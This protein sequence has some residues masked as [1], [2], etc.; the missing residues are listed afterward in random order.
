M[1]KKY[2]KRINS[3]KRSDSGATFTIEFMFIFVVIFVLFMAMVD[4]GL[5]FNNRSLITNMTQDAARTVAIHGGDSTKITVS[6][7]NNVSP[8]VQLRNALNS[9]YSGNR[10]ITISS[11]TCS[12]RGEV[13][14]S[15]RDKTVSCSV[16]WTYSG[17]VGGSPFRM[18]PNTTTTTMYSVSEVWF[19]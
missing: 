18:S 15:S 17:L 1:F 2:T 6:K 4:L 11:V 5:Y 8:S 12:P 19:K 9:Q 16:T 7:Y 10:M 13:K 14:E 3:H